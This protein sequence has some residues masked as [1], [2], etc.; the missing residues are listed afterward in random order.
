MIMAYYRLG[1]WEDA[2]RSMKRLLGYAHDFRMDNLIDFG[3]T[4]Y[5]LREPSTAFMTI[6]VCRPR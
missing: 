3:K 1:H 2:R 4:P 5:Q 6:G